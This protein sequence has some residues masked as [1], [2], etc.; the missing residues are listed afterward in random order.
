MFALLRNVLIERSNG[1]GNE[2][3]HESASDRTSRGLHF[4]H[5]LERK[6]VSRTPASSCW[7]SKKLALRLEVSC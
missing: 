1:G 3:G 6:C 5:W 7:I 2:L 4:L